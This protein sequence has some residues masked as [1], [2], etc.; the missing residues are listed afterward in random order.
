MKEKQNNKKIDFLI[1]AFTIGNT[2][3]T[4]YSFKVS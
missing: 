1:S 4:K 3:K 2:R